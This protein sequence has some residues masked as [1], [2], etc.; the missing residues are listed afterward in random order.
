MSTDIGKQKG[1]MIGLDI[2]R[3]LSMVLITFRHFIGYAG[4]TDA[5]EALSVNG[6]L[7]S[8]LNVLCGSAV[9]VFVLISGYFLI[10]SRFKWS[11][12]LRIWGETFFYSV[13]CF[14]AFGFF[15]ALRREEAEEK[16]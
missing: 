4:L 12:V 14:A 1:R 11:R 16:S 3:I 9:N 15:C 6:I 13:I 2:L 10:D 7:I 8:V 5:V